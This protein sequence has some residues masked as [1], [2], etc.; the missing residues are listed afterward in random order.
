VEWVLLF[1]MAPLALRVWWHPAVLLTLLALVTAAGSRWLVGQRFP[2]YQPLWRGPVGRDERR[3][4]KRLLWRFALSAGLL[5]ALVWLFAPDK[6]FA[7]PR[8]QPRLWLL[9]L[10]F[11]PL[12]SAYPQELIYRALFFGRYRPLFPNA[13]ALLLANAAAFG[14]LHL[15]FQNW[16]AVLLTLVGGGLFAET[17]ARTYSLR[18]VWLEHSLYGIFIFTVGLG[19]YFY[20]GSVS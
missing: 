17:Y 18:L 9:I 7:M 16:P 5:T 11:Y 13:Q 8:H 6:L 1:V 12:F 20:H 19:E 4:L 2:H 15:V 14:F 3:Q 10:L